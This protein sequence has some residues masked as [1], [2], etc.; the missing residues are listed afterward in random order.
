MA[1]ET[2]PSSARE[3]RAGPSSDLAERWSR[4]PRGPARDRVHAVLEIAEIAVTPPLAGPDGMRLVDDHTLLV[5]EGQAGRVSRVTISGDTATAA[6][7]ATDLDQ[8]TG[9]VQARGDAWVSEGQLGRLFAMPALAPKLP[10][11]V[12]RV[13]L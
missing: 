1:Q 4:A 6:P 5:I 7:L 10:F 13:A 12:R 8:P 2:D 11:S 3:T 9:V